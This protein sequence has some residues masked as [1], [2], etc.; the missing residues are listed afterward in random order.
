[1]VAVAALC[2]LLACATPSRERLGDIRL[3]PYGSLTAPLSTFS[4]QQGRILSPDLDLTV[5]PDGCIRGLVHRAPLQLCQKQAPPPQREGASKIQ[6]WQ[7]L[8]GD[9]VV[10]I[11][12]QGKRLRADGFLSTGGGSGRPLQATIPLGQGRQWDEL[13]NNPALLAVA[14]A[15]AGVSGEPDSDAAER[16]TR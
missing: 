2:A 5:E 8:G 16:L 14:A 4:V 7:G 13:R 11:E 1:L 3:R 12:E 15:V 9:F 10:E 6:H